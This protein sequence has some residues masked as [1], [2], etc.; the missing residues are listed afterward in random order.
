METPAVRKIGGMVLFARTM[1]PLKTDSLVHVEIGAAI[2]EGTTA[3]EARP[4][5]P[6]RRPSV[7]V[8]Q[9]WTRRRP[10]GSVIAADMA[11]MGICDGRVGW[12]VWDVAE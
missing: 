2:R 6:N 4:V 9:S 7:T 8:E 12:L 10:C 11:E 5:E 3:K 1:R